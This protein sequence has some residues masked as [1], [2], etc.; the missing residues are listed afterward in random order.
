MEAPRQLQ[1]AANEQEDI[2]ITRREYEE[3]NIITI[4]FGP[5]VEASLDTIGETVIVVA[6]D[7]QF[8]FERP[9]EATDITTND[10]MLIIK[11]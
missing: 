9:A 11:E 2:T 1:S 7:H 6:G 3:E 4:D 8:E 10:G 5:D